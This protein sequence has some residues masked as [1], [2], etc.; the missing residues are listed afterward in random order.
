MEKVSRRQFLQTAIGGSVAI[1]GML[2]SAG[3]Q[4]PPQSRLKM[5]L[6]GCGWYGMVDAQAA[7]KVGGVEIIAICDVDSQHLKDSADKLE[8]LQG[9]RP[10]MF[11]DY[12]KLLAVPELK[13]VIIATPPH[14]HALPFL[15]ALDRGLDIYAEKPLAYDIREGQ[16]MVAAAKK[17]DRIVQVGFQRR[18]STAIREVRDYIQQGR[19]GRIIQAEVQIHYTAGMRDTTVQDPPESLDWDLWCG[20]APKLPY[21]PQ[22]GHFA[23]RLEKAYGNGHLV[24]WGI[25]LMDATRWILNETMPSSVQ[26][27]GGIYVFKDKITTPDI[28]NAH[29]EFDTCPVNWQHR[30]WGAREYTPSLSNG[31]M[32]YGEKG[33]VFVTDNRWEIMS[34]DR[35][36]QPQ[37]KESRADAGTLHMADFLTSVRTRQQPLCSPQD[38]CNS[39]S[40]VQL[41]MIAYE[42]GRKI[43]W[44]RDAQQI[45]GNRRAVA[46]MKREY[47]APWEHPFKG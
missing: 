29:F 24:D 9:T 44:D 6:I 18:Q 30:M 11:K 21:S 32:L 28:M 20:P 36:S 42:L 16:A 25:H 47:R 12:K 1:S 26:A 34:K 23:W 46:L 35:N 40:T 13:A 2:G 8:S 4:N 14:W 17:T 37:V 43:Q 39:T 31:I 22:I 33:T 3:A 41:A 5:G 19:L 27:S 15:A 7:L 10:Q 38:A 45:T